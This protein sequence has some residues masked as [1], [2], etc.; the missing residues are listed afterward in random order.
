MRVFLHH[1]GHILQA[2]HIARGITVHNLLLHVIER[3]ERLFYVYRQDILRSLYASA[4]GHKPLGKQLSGDELL[5]QS[6]MRQT[7]RI[8]VNGNLFLS[9]SADGQTSHTGNTAQPVFQFIHVVRQFPIGFVLALH[10]NQQCRSIAEIIHHLHGQHIR[11]QLR[12]ERGHSV[13]EL[14]PEL[15]FVV[16]VI[17]QFHLHKHDSVAGGRKSL[18]FFTSL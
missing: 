18:S 16:Q 1:T 13:L 14:A 8:Q 10:G 17:I 11:R 12:L 5:V 15:I 7:L 2:Y 6:V 9:F 4:G 3:V